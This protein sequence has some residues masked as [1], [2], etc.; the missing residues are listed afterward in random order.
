MFGYH[1][2][3][4]RVDLSNRKVEVEDLDENLIRKYIGGLGIE[5]KILYEE[6]TPETDPL[7][8]GNILMAV[9]GPYTGTGVPTSGRHHLVNRQNG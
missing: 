2:K 5:A 6:T 4:L 9:T 3:L 8:P 1:K 7:S